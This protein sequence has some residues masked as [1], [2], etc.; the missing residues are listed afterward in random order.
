MPSLHDTQA[1]IMGALRGAPPA[2][3]VG[4]LLRAGRGVA[5][6][7][8]LQVYR[9]NLHASLGA[10]LEAV[11]PVLARLVGAAFF[12]Q[13][14]RGYL[15]RHP[16]RSGNLHAFGAQMPA[17][18]KTQASLSDHAYLADVAGLEWAAHEVYHEADDTAF[19]VAGLGALDDAARLRLRLH[20]QLATRFVASAYPVLA[21]W[22]ANQPGADAATRVFL[23]EGGVRLLVARTG[24][25]VEFR[26]LGVAEERWLRALAEGRSLAAAVQSA[27][28]LDPSFD[29]GATLGRHLGL[30]SFRGWS[31]AREGQA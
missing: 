11:Y 16:S 10:A 25:E 23:D 26:I 30:G 7:R 13:L 6:E 8:R 24:F 9:N 27:L 2:L 22:K 20:L 28:A 18:L 1:L 17:F 14:A 19:D 31:L 12:R 29:L 4:A 15:E 21:I 3:P 5:P